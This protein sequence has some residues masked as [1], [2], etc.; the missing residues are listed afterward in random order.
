MRSGAGV[1]NSIRNLM[2]F[3]WILVVD[4]NVEVILLF[5]LVIDELIICILYGSNLYQAYFIMLIY[6]NIFLFGAYK[7][8]IFCS[9][10]NAFVGVIYSLFA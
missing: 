4:D 10:S 2:G 8:L 1:M 7:Q 3:L 9:E 6:T 5:S